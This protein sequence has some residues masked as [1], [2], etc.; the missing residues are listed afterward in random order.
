M[1]AQKM[2]S[3]RRI[4]IYEKDAKE[5][6]TTGLHLANCFTLRRET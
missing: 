6:A 5:S 4:N 3:V 1:R 2:D